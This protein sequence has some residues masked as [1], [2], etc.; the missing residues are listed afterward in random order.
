M[1]VD[2][3]AGCLSAIVLLLSIV[4]MCWALNHRNQEIEHRLDRLENAVHLP[5]E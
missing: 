2:D 3:G 1:R 5:S 4:F